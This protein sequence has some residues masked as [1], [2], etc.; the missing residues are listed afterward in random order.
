[1]E[2]FPGEVV[3]RDGEIR[4]GSDV[5]LQLRDDV[6]F[7][8]WSGCAW[9]EK[10]HVRQRVLVHQPDVAEI[11]HHCSLARRLSLNARRRDT[12]R[13]EHLP[14]VSKRVMKKCVRNVAFALP[15]EGVRT[16]RARHGSSQLTPSRVDGRMRIEQRIGVRVRLL[17]RQSQDARDGLSAEQL[18]VA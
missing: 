13:R 1:M 12:R 5:S 6:I 11:R 2:F 3:I 7:V 8:L 10:A 17:F 18:I 15:E 4:A 14:M 16:R 9:C